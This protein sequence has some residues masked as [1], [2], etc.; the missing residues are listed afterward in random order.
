MPEHIQP[1]NYK[2]SLEALDKRATTHD[3]AA[4]ETLTD[5][6]LQVEHARSNSATRSAQIRKELARRAL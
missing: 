2:S 1:V 4:L 6:E 3:H 5:Q